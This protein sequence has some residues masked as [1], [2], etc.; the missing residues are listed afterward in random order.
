MF[1]TDD[2]AKKV[3]DLA[4]EAASKK[5]M[6]PIWHRKPTLNRFMITFEERL[7]GWI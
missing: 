3:I 5:W 7:A 4:I 2:S 6:T 1:P